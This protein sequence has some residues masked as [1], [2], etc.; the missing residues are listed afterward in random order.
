MFDAAMPYQQPLPRL[1]CHDLRLGDWGPYSKRY[2]GISHIPDVRS[3]MRF[4]LSVFPG[5]FRRSVQ[6]PNVLWES[7]YHPWE[8]AADLSFYSHR[9]EVIW[10]DQLYC[11]VSFSRLDRN[12]TLIRTACVNRGDQPQNMVLHYAAYVNPPPKGPPSRDPVAPARVDIPPGAFWTAAMTYFDLRMRPDDPRASLTP[13]GQL[14]GEVREH[15]LVD[16]VGLGGGFAAQAGDRVVYHLTIAEGI[17]DAM[18][19]LRFRL[20]T[21]LTLSLGLGGLVDREIHLAGTGQIEVAIVPLGAIEAGLAELSIQSR[22]GSPLLTDGFFIAPAAQASQVRFVPVVWNYVPQMTAGPRD[23]TLVLKYEHIDCH[24]GLA[25]AHAGMVREFHG[26]D[27]DCMLRLNAHKHTARTLRGEGQGHFA[28]VFMYPIFVPPRG[29]E[30]LYGLVTA[31]NEQEV[32]DRLV[33][34]DAASP[35]LERQ[36]AAARSRAV[37]LTPNQAGGSYQFSQDRMAATTL[38]GVVYPVRTAG[39]WIRHNTP[40]RWWDCLYTW[41]SGFLGLGLLEL[42]VERAID[43]LNAYMTPPGRKDAAFVH[44]GTPVPVQAYLYQSLWSR[45]QSRELLAH[46]YGPMQRYHRFLAGRSD[47]STTR[48]Q[49]SNLLQTWDYFYNSGGW[50]DYPPQVH[51]HKNKIAARVSPAANTSHAIRTARILKA[52]ADILGEPQKEYDDD[53]AA[54]GEALQRHAWDD[55]AGYFSYV[56]HDESGQPTGPLRHESGVNFNMGMDGASPLFAG[57]CTE[58]QQAGLVEHLMSDRG[59]WSR[60]GLSTVDQ[61]AP[62]YRPDGYWNGAVWM[63][64]QWFFWRA[65]LDLGMADHAHRIACTALGIW[66]QEVDESYNCYEHFMVQTGK[67]AGWHQFTG[68]SSPVLIW[69]GAYH[70]PGTLSMGMDGWVHA[71][72]WAPGYRGLTA[73]LTLNGRPGHQATAIVC[74]SDTSDY[75]VTWNG[76]PIKANQR[77]PGTLEVVL[78]AAGVGILIVSPRSLDDSPATL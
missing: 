66:R 61:S 58:A 3:G 2:I 67:G 55:E 9:H 33:A 17:S 5:L 8:A 19:G 39:T 30:R 6:V 77:Y 76:Q 22:G 52:A 57:V 53:I 51:V 24:Y 21:G 40:G 54:F 32:C 23:N 41:D 64:H 31:G 34:F 26:G 74:L 70:R 18:L 12:A 63:P 28:N 42:D 43:C 35:D 72:Q 14:R 78:P 25:W 10:K 37:A 36:Y 68:L 73:Q 56:V 13:D 20:D 59:M 15:G 69:Y 46:F 38:S 50:D 27:L 47:G 16:G 29:E 4:D 62:Y 1:G 48:R 49:K 7:A 45:T 75:A 11:D 60:S 65:M 71:C 44:H